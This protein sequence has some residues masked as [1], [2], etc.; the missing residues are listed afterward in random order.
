MRIRLSRMLRRMGGYEARPDKR[1]KGSEEF[2]HF[3]PSPKYAFLYGRGGR[4]K[5]AGRGGWLGL[6]ESNL[7]IQIQSL[8]SYH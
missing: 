4:S 7:R 5:A 2:P 8:L 3:T 6:E 1:G